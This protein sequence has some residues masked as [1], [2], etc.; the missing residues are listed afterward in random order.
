MSKTWMAVVAA[1]LMAIPA[2]AQQMPIEERAKAQA[3]V[4]KEGLQLTDEQTAQ[5]ADAL[6]PKLEA[7]KAGW[8]KKQ[9]GDE[10]G[11]KAI[12]KESGMAFNKALMG[13][14]TPAQKEV[15]KTAKE[16]LMAKANAIK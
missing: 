11:A 6:I 9:D 16:A 5:V 10:E 3:E 13:I 12:W 8:L 1:A 2:I 14:L 15:Y 7:G 4:F